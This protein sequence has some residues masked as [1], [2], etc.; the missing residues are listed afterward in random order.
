MP[1]HACL[2]ALFACC[3]FSALA[4]A[5][6]SRD[7]AG[8]PGG[9]LSA[10]ALNQT[11]NAGGPGGLLSPPAL[12]QTTLD[13]D[14]ARLYYIRVPKTGSTSLR[15]HVKACD[16][17]RYHNHALG[18]LVPQ[19]QCNSTHVHVKEPDAIVFGVVRAPCKHFDSVHRHLLSH[20]WLHLPYG[21]QT[22]Q[23]AQW[24]IA[25]RR[26]ECNQASPGHCAVVTNDPTFAVQ[27]FARKILGEY[28]P[29]VSRFRARVMLLPQAFHLPDAPW[30]R[31]VCY[32]SNRTELTRQ[33]NQVFA[34]ADVR[35]LILP[36]ALERT[37]RRVNTLFSPRAL[38]GPVCQLIKTE[39]YP[40]DV[41]LYE[42]QYGPKALRRALRR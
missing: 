42:K 13:A 22:M 16:A 28:P 1:T 3:L 27:A 4:L 32:S 14:G 9:L 8:R 35:C 7:H 30:S 31:P 33:V 18:C 5:Q 23:L 6:L 37:T 34:D 39:L 40:E 2:A 20:R 10:P 25:L 11:T 41:A 17:V 38:P 15:K 19:E 24:L 29:R 12:S 26:S 21:N 36:Q